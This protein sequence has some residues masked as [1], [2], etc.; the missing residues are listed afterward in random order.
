MSAPLMYR[1]DG[2]A[3]RPLPYFRKLALV[4]FKPEETYR[5]G[6]ISDRS[7]NSHR[8]FFACVY[9][10]WANLREDEADQ[11][12]SADHLRKWALTYTQFCDVYYYNAAS[13]A[14]VVRI[15]DYLKKRSDVSRIDVDLQSKRVIEY[16]P[17]SQALAAMPNNRIFQASKTA[18]L[19]VLAKKLGVSIEQIEKA[20][21]RAA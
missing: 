11:F 8:H 1:W 10:A 7:M 12:P 19:D 15:I 17:H 9:E 5:L 13:S 21:R 16:V 3:M 14:E 20:A 18:V 6:E 4:Q 2:E